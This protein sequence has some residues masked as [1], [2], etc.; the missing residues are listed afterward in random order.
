MKKIFLV[1]VLLVSVF[2]LCA[3]DK[4]KTY[5]TGDGI[6]FSLTKGKITNFTITGIHPY[7]DG[8]L[9]KLTDK[10]KVTLEY[11]VKKGSTY[12]GRSFRVAGYDEKMKME[13]YEEF[14]Y[15]GTITDIK[16]NCMTVLCSE[17]KD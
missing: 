12:Y 3:E 1:L 5:N 2:I 11:Y 14:Y 17:Y 16:P 9:L 8:Y 7:N 10:E 4:T 13:Y 15:I 6:S